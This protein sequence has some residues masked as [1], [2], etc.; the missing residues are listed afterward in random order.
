MK[1]NRKIHFLNDFALHLIIYLLKYLFKNMLYTYYIF[2]TCDMLT[3]QNVVLEDG[4]LI[5]RH[6]TMNSS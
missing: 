6:V 2:I 4:E 1:L 5:F 3:K